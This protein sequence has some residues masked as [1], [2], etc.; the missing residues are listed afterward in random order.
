MDCLRCQSLL[1]PEVFVDY[2]ASG[3]AMSFLGY[4]CLSCGDIL[5]TT[6]LRHRAGHLVLRRTTP[7]LPM[8]VR[9]G[10]TLLRRD[11]SEG[12]TKCW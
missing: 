7:R 1:I 8:S 6:I 12:C 2:G 5:D 3:G 4:R 10:S 11:G 9:A